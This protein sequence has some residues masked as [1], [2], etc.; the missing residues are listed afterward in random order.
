[1]EVREYF[2]SYNVQQVLNDYITTLAGQKTEPGFVYERKE[3]I[4]Q[5]L[6]FFLKK[7]SFWDEYTQ[8][9]ISYIGEVFYDQLKGKNISENGL[10]AM[11]T[12]CLRFVLE[13]SIYQANNNYSAFFR[14]QQDFALENLELFDSASQAQ[15]KY[16]FYEMPINIVRDFIT[17]DN[18]KTYRDFI[19]A[20]DK[21]N[22]FEEKWDSYIEDKEKR[23]EELSETLKKHETAF[24]FVGLYAGFSE[25]ADIKKNELKNSKR[26]LF[27]LAPVLTLPIIGE[28]L[29]LTLMPKSEN[30]VNH[31]IVSIP[32]LSLTLILIYFFRVVLNNFNSIRAQLMQLELRKSLCQ[33]IQSYAEYSKEIRVDTVNPLAKFEEII[34]SNIMGSDEKTPSTFDGIEQLAG[35][36]KAIKNK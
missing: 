5:M 28:A 23:V 4:L 33:F 10:N 25:L 7:R 27:L 18:V 11:F 20:V 19:N 12:D 26:L 6:R 31:L 9:N 24:N 2:N 17:Q 1:M 35:M 36:I 32:V 30:V 21:A 29:T 3:K 13:A 34:F 22:D 8:H 16:A 15:I 14:V